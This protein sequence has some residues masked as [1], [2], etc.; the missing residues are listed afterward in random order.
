MKQTEKQNKPALSGAK[1]MVMSKFSFEEN[2]SVLRTTRI[3]RK[4]SQDEMADKLDYAHT[5]Y[6]EIERGRRPVRRETADRIAS[7]LHSKVETL[8][9]PQGKKLV[10]KKA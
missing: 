6:G 1:K 5:T 2:P 3:S 4:L 7:I 8:F 10:A 9:S